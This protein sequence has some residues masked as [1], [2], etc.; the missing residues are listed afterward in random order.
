MEHSRG[1]RIEHA[2]HAVLRSAR[3]IFLQ[4]VE[5]D[6]SQACLNE[7]FTLGCLSVR[8]RRRVGGGSHQSEDL[9]IIEDFDDHPRDL[10]RNWKCYHSCGLSSE[11]YRGTRDQAPYTFQQLG[12][13]KSES[14]IR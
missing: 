5:P 8:N 13:A 9:F 7:L 6:A 14:L 10:P 4:L 2:E 12:N 1:R 3:G 11:Q